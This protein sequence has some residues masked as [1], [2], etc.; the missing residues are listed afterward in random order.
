MGKD[1]TD[2]VNKTIDTLEERLV[3]HSSKIV[4]DIGNN[5]DLQRID[6][7]SVADGAVGLFH[8]GPDKN[9]YEIEVRPITQGRHKNLWGNLIKK[10]ENR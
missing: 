6:M 10:R 9:A 5:P 4:A 1:F 2:M 7:W 8:Y 3:T